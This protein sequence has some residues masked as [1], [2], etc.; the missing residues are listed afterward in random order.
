[1]KPSLV[2]LAAGAGSRYGGIK[3]I[4]SIG[5][6]DETL[7]DYSIF[8]AKRAGFGKVYFIIRHAIEADFTERLFNRIS[9]N[10]DA[11]YV[12]QE[13]DTLL[14]EEQAKIAQNRT[15]PW[16][17]GHALLCAKN[18]V[19]EPFAAINA[20]D[21]YG[22]NA[23][24]VMAEYLSKL[25]VTDTDYAMVAYNL[26]KTMTL[27]GSVSRGICTTS[28]DGA[29]LDTITENT[30]I[31]FDTNNKQATQENIEKLPVVSDYNGKSVSLTGKEWVSMNFFG[32]TPEFFNGLQQYFDNFIQQN[33]SSE[34]AEAFLPEA[35]S[36]QISKKTGKIRFLTTPDQWYGMT[37]KEDRDLVKNGIASLV[38][39]GIYPEK[40]WP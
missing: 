17:T 6:H 37:Y 31:F 10:I 20:D 13:K 32:F 22:A 19:K 21:F 1:M 7:L 4:D 24:K 11:E 8:D 25:S 2:V 12:F 5:K 9:R 14:T 35:A 26:R 34:K 30:K 29:W 40:L 36:L 15:K 28:S 39:K 33:I 38:S 3:Q 16:G 23:Y 27:S 18:A